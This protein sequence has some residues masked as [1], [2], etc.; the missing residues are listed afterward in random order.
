MSDP[1]S[2]LI[3]P[4]EDNRGL[5][6]SLLTVIDALNAVT[7][8]LGIVEDILAAA[9]LATRRI[10][11]IPM[12]W[13]GVWTASF[14]YLHGDVVTRNLLLMIA[15]K[16]TTET[17]V[18]A[19]N[20]WDLLLDGSGGGGGTFSHARVSQVT[21]TSVPNDN[22]AHVMNFDLSVEDSNNLHSTTV[23]N[24]RITADVN[25]IWTASAQFYSSSVTLEWGLINVFI[26]L[27]LGS[28]AV[29]NEVK[30]QGLNTGFDG[31]ATANITGGDFRMVAGDYIRL[32]VQLRP[33]D[34]SSGSITTWMSMR[35]VAD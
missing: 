3:L 8:R 17:P 34:E 10:G 29:G 31:P 1:F 18:L 28:L 23:N 26:L 15:N 20:D 21:K 12:T 6:S 9:G 2:P 32:A 25:G 24:S 19:A 13:L 30:I 27:S 5:Q 11:A 4:T 7:P 35:R 14:V 16:T 33:E 22:F